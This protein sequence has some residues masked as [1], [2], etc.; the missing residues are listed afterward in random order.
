MI[1]K[2]SAQASFNLDPA[3]A[4]CMYAQLPDLVKQGRG[5][6]TRNN[7]FQQTTGSPINR[8][9]K[10]HSEKSGAVAALNSSHELPVRP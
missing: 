5:E 8:L 7:N 1:L 10:T 3:V 9:T 4:L 6:A 2:A